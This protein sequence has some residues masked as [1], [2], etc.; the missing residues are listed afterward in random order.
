MASDEHDLDVQF[1]GGRTDDGM[2][3]DLDMD[4]DMNDEQS[5]ERS[6]TAHAIEGVRAGVSAYAGSAE[7]VAGLVKHTMPD[8]MTK[9]V[10]VLEE[11]TADVLEEVKKTQDIIRPQVEV[12]TDSVKKILPE[13]RMRSMVEK[14][15]KRFDLNQQQYE[16]KKTAEEQHN[17]SVASKLD[18]MFKLERRQKNEADVQGKVE[19]NITRTIT[20]TNHIATLHALKS[21]EASAEESSRYT[22][23][24]T[25]KFQRRSLEL[26]Y[27][28]VF[29]TRSLLEET[30]KTSKVRNQQF[31]NITKNTALPEYAKLRLMERMGEKTRDDAIDFAKESM[32]GEHGPLGDAVIDLK[33]FVKTT[34]T[35]VRETITGATDGLEGFAGGIEMNREVNEMSGKSELSTNVEMGSGFLLDFLLKSG[36]DKVRGDPDDKTGKLNVLISK[37]EDAGHELPDNVKGYLDKIRSGKDNVAAKAWDG[38]VDFLTSAITHKKSFTA[39]INDELNPEG[40]VLDKNMYDSVTEVIPGYLARILQEH[41]ATRLGGLPELILFDRKMARFTSDTG[42]SASIAKSIHQSNAK[43]VE[44]FATNVDKI[45][46]DAQLKNE[47]ILSDDEYDKIRSLMVLALAES[48][49][50][51]SPIRNYTQLM[52]NPE[53]MKAMSDDPALMDKLTKLFSKENSDHWDRNEVVDDFNAVNKHMPNMRGGIIALSKLYGMD[54]LVRDGLVKVEGEE[55]ELSKHAM[56]DI[57]NGKYEDTELSD[58]ENDRVAGRYNATNNDGYEGSSSSVVNNVDNSNAM[59]SSFLEECCTKQLA[60]LETIETEVANIDMSYLEECCMEQLEVL[61]LIAKNTAK[62]DTPEAPNDNSVD[63]LS[64]LD[65]IVANTARMN[66]E[67]L[68]ELGLEQLEVLE[69]IAK[70][71]SNDDDTPEVPNDNS[72]DQLSRLDTIVA[73]TA[74]MN[75][76]TLEELGLEQLDALQLIARNTSNNDDDLNTGTATVTERTYAY[77]E[78]RPVHDALAFKALTGIDESIKDVSVKVVNMEGMFDGIGDTLKNAADTFSGMAGVKKI[79]DLADHLGEMSLDDVRNA[80]DDTYERARGGVQNQLDKSGILDMRFGEVIGAGFDTAWRGMQAVAMLG[81]HAMQSTVNTATGFMDN[82][83]KKEDGTVGGELAKG[84]I[85]AGKT[86]KDTGKMIFNQSMELAHTMIGGVNKMANKAW[87]AMPAGWNK[88]VEGFNWMASALKSIP[89]NPL[90]GPKDVYSTGFDRPIL[91]KIVMENGGYFDKATGAEVKTLKDI[92]GEVIDGEGNT[93]LTIEMMENGL[94]DTHGNSLTSIYGKIRSR[95]GLSGGLMGKLGKIG[96]WAKGKLLSVGGFVSNLWSSITGWNVIAGENMGDLLSYQEQQ[97]NTQQQ[98]LSF[99]HTK[100]D[101]KYND[102]DGDGTR[103]GSWTEADIASTQARDGVFRRAEQSGG[104]G[105]STYLSAIGT[106][107]GGVLSATGSSASNFAETAAAVAAANALTGGASSATKAVKKRK[108]AAANQGRSYKELR[109]F[110]LS[111]KEAADFMRGEKAAN[112]LNKNAAVDKV[113]DVAAAV[114]YARDKAAF[115]HE[116]MSSAEAS[117]AAKDVGKQRR[118]DRVKKIRRS[119]GNAKDYVEKIVKDV[120]KQVREGVSSSTTST[121]RPDSWAR[122]YRKRGVERLGAGVNSAHAN[123]TDY[124]R[125]YEANIKEGMSRKDA[126]SAAAAEKNDRRYAKRMA[127]YSGNEAVEYARDLKDLKRAGFMDNSAARLARKAAKERKDERIAYEQRTKHQGGLRRGAGGLVRGTGRLGAGIA[128]GIGRAGKK[129]G[130]LG[131]RLVGGTAGILAGGATSLAEVAIGAGTSLAGAALPLL[132]N[133][134]GLAIMAAASVGVAVAYRKEIAE[135]FGKFVDYASDKMIDGG[136][137]LQN[138]WDAGAAWSIEAVGSVARATRSFGSMVSDKVIGMWEWMANKGNSLWD[139]ASDKG[140]SMK[141]GLKSSYE[142][143]K[144]A[145][146]SV[147]STVAG[148]LGVGVKEMTDEAKL[149]TP[150]EIQMAYLTDTVADVVISN[151]DIIN[152]EIKRRNNL[153]RDANGSA[154]I[155]HTSERMKG[156]SSFGSNATTIIDGYKMDKPDANRWSQLG[157]LERLRMRMYGMATDAKFSTKLKTL[158]GVEADIIT[159][160]GLKVVRNK[161]V[162]DGSL[163]NGFLMNHFDISGDGTYNPDTD[164]AD[165]IHQSNLDHWFAQRFIPVIKLTLQAMINSKMTPDLAQIPL[166]KGVDGIVFI[167]NLIK[168]LHEAKTDPA[169]AVLQ[170]SSTSPF[171]NL[172]IKNAGFWKSMWSTTK[173]AGDADV[174]PPLDIDALIASLQ[175][176]MNDFASG[177]RVKRDEFGRADF[178]LYSDGDVD[179]ENFNKLNYKSKMLIGYGKTIAERK[180]LHKLRSKS[181]TLG[182]MLEDPGNRDV[183]KQNKVDIEQLT[184]ALNAEVAALVKT[185]A[186]TLGNVYGFAPG[187]PD[188]GSI[189]SSGFERADGAGAESM[190][191]LELEFR[192]HVCGMAREWYSHTGTKLKF[193]A[194]YRSVEKHQNLYNNK[195]VAEP[196]SVSPYTRGMAISVDAKQVEKLDETGLLSK[197]GLTI[198]VGGDPSTIEPM[199][200]QFNIAKY[201]DDVGALRG[202]MHTQYQRG[203]HGWG[204]VNSEWKMGDPRRNAIYQSN[205]SGYR[206]R[207]VNI[208]LALLDAEKDKFTTK[209]RGRR[210][211]RTTVKDMTKKIVDESLTPETKAGGTKEEVAAFIKTAQQ[212]EGVKKLNKELLAVKAKRSIAA[213]AGDH[214]MVKRLGIESKALQAEIKELE[215]KE[216]LLGVSAPVGA[217]GTPAVSP[218]V[219]NTAAVA[220]LAATKV[221]DAAVKKAAEAVG[222]DGKVISAAAAVTR[223]RS[224]TGTVAPVMTTRGRGTTDVVAPITTT[225]GRGVSE[226]GG[227]ES[228]SRGRG[229]IEVAP[230]VAKGRGSAVPATTN[231]T[232][233]RGAPVP[234]VTRG[235]GAPSVAS[236]VPTSTISSTVNNAAVLAAAGVV[237]VVKSTP[238]TRGRG[239]GAAET[240]TVEIIKPAVVAAPKA[241]VI[242]AVAAPV[243]KSAGDPSVYSNIYTPPKSHKHLER[244]AAAIPAVLAPAMAAPVVK[245]AGEPSVY[246]NIYTPPKSHKHLERRATPK[247]VTVASGHKKPSPDLL[248]KVKAALARYKPEEDPINNKPTT[249]GRLAEVT[250]PVA[251]ASAILNNVKVGK[252]RSVPAEEGEDPLYAMLRYKHRKDKGRGE[253][254]IQVSKNIDKY[255]REQGIPVHHARAIIAQESA[256]GGNV[257]SKKAAYGVGQFFGAAWSDTNKRKSIRNH[258]DVKGTSTK[259]TDNPTGKRHALYSMAY[260]KAMYNRSKRRHGAKFIE[261]LGTFGYYAPYFMGPGGSDKFYA[262]YKKNP[263]TKMSDVLSADAIGSN[264]E[265]FKG[266]T[267][268][269]GMAGVNKKLATRRREYK[270]KDNYDKPKSTPSVAASIGAAGAMGAAGPTAGFKA[271]GITGMVGGG[272][273]STPLGGDDNNGIPPLMESETRKTSS[274]TPNSVYGKKSTP[275]EFESKSTSTTTVMN[276][277]GNV[278]TGTGVPNARIP[279]TTV[280]TSAEPV[281]DVR[282]TSID[283]VL[284]SSR[285]TQ[286]NMLSVMQEILKATKEGGGIANG[287]GQP[288]ASNPTKGGLKQNNPNKKPVYT[289]SKTAVVQD[290]IPKPT[291][292]INH[293]Q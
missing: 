234:V 169:Y 249:A 137:Y 218:A 50:S 96:N 216:K 160:K 143:I 73:N 78:D 35:T 116:G 101:R 80:V 145:G 161:V 202:T 224:S 83:L 6:P 280:E 207:K 250:A 95:L 178:E 268:A 68:E 220:A 94:F 24:I 206:Q 184:T 70:N 291:F 112:Q 174:L 264:A 103:D 267:L 26:Q 252:A 223:G 146:V 261:K 247:P 228:E 14:L 293:G 69:L 183:A 154:Y 36:L 150:R 147:Y 140:N 77:G 75:A 85:M 191:K 40:Y 246:S 287:A 165:A 99:L 129:V 142:G 65:T 67:T 34:L 3:L 9:S 91:L 190:T 119:G 130:G 258:P 173:L 172:N 47:E 13:G 20:A 233:G 242:P 244:Q 84:A 122:R 72:V 221:A 131:A 31:E 199:V 107:V 117:D 92:K 33:D 272:P 201:L 123:L 43:N 262:A 265:S 118:R 187:L 88:L 21:I 266:K 251:G 52:L 8:R 134:I 175:M 292:N 236:A 2:E 263:N 273:V 208:P 222:A 152:N 212:S 283:D 275:D 192:K 7:N 125:D 235:R 170:Q 19:T 226:V 120:N 149:K 144:E 133:P 82:V 105:L 151:T 162:V 188:V 288:D 49:N 17:E 102:R 182:N 37:L 113:L 10:E 12:L 41:Q 16:N 127:G 32:F 241:S 4:F 230:T 108:K 180:K 111:R 163:N 260:M 279:V 93:L 109:A 285:T 25:S 45:L 23:E 259:R 54:R 203:G 198:P 44:G 269:E 219:V 22:L 284:Q 210:N 38:I 253:V 51:G 60:V 141:Q 286:E 63:Q 289:R 164:S 110:G 176:S 232:R 231:D 81:T 153:R 196:A 89:L 97:L 167:N 168:V 240:P 238:A 243:V 229:A 276:A 282:I 211:Q 214:V 159:R 128:G 29:L 104:D 28:Q 278:F 139:W 171:E 194:G 166:L 79:K 185:G 255:A 179:L 66:A 115:M 62:D 76:E 227:Q 27:K 256:F 200:I 46:D 248:N 181:R 274:V 254:Q 270:L 217:D 58:S 61:E 124:G 136:T 213:K 100:F 237:E 106:A 204:S 90:D 74:R 114:E 86:A 71:T 11:G 205:I 186:E 271:A 257:G 59:D 148:W 281:Q 158:R 156:S 157:T 197:Y 189:D 56:T 57:L 132:T 239:R 15:E 138:E 135:G 1:E 225:R 5:D 277:G 55:Y 87:E 121:P 209:T 177:N 155:E 195:L 126:R 193:L 64:R 98:M 290:S 245:S 42:M 215:A 48:M 53:V 39:R 18:D 30:I